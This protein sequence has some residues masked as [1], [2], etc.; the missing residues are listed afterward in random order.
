MAKASSP[1]FRLDHW[2]QNLVLRA[3]IGA[4]LVLPYRWRVPLCGWVF[5]RLI[6]PLAGYS[7]RIRDNLALIFPDMPEAEIRHMLRAVPNNVGRT[8]IEM[9]SGD[10][11]IARAKAAPLHG[12]GL[13]AL[14]EARAAGRPVVLVTGHFGN[15]D[16]SRAAL[17]A[18]GFPVGGLYRPMTN[19]YFNAHY[20]AAIRHI[21]E[22][23]F[24][25]GRQGMAAM[26]RFLRQGGMLGIVQD[27]HMKYA[28]VLR[29]FGQPAKTAL[30]AAELALKYDALLVPSYAIRQPDGLSFDILVD[31]PIPHSTAEV[32]TQALNDHLET[33]VRQNLDQWFWIHKRWK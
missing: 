4:L 2:L 1:G 28:P 31:A 32:M 18:R 15:Y 30:S 23:L 25:R 10:E 13:A 7:R 27:Q 19:A 16:A 20:V 29:F 24:A 14:E 5:A 6:A 3:L 11:F 33:H 12:P 8:V 17:I 26:I 22:P 21:G 9:Y